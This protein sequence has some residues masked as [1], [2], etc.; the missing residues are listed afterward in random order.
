MN[1]KKLFSN[2][3][4]CTLEIDQFNPNLPQAWSG[5]TDGNYLFP[6]NDIDCTP[7]KWL[8]LH[9]V[10][11]NDLSWISD[12]FPNLEMLRIDFQKNQS[13]TSLNGI[14]LLSNLHALIINDG[15]GELSL[16]YN[17]KL[18]LDYLI[19]GGSKSDQYKMDAHVIV[20]KPIYVKILFTF[21]DRK[22]HLK[23]LNCDSLYLSG[24]RDETGKIYIHFE[25]DAKDLK[26]VLD[27][28]L[29]T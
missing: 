3:T 19:F 5:K 15:G 28:L 6:H 20:N 17:E 22:E 1:V 10:K 13:L 24:L 26:F 14:E 4:K 25:G 11:T 16:D 8:M 23:E 29:N 9:D 27:P 7:M 12:L 18:K 2:K 21:V